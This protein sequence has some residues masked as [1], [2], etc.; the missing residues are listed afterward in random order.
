M[1]TPSSDRQVISNK[2]WILT[3]CWRN[4]TPLGSTFELKQKEENIDIYLCF[5]EFYVFYTAGVAIDF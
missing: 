2:N 4:S 5:S 3:G 1:V